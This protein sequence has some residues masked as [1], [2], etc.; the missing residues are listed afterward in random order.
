[1]GDEGIQVVTLTIRNVP[2]ERIA[3]IKRAAT[4]NG[5]TVEEEVR[6]LLIT[7]YSCKEAATDSTPHGTTCNSSGDV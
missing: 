2:D 3:R 1:M 7:Q 6:E 5:R 4:R